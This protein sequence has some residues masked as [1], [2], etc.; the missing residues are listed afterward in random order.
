MSYQSLQLR[1]SR[2]IPSNNPADGLSSRLFGLDSGYSFV[3]V[4]LHSNAVTGLSGSSLSHFT[5]FPS[6]H[7]RRVN[8]FSQNLLEME[9]MS[10]PY[11]FPPFGSVGLV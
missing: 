1:L 4:A 6:R 2:V 3:L 8:L 9:D 7:P 11:V 5:L 10:N